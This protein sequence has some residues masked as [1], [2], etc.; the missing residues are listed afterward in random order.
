MSWSPGSGLLIR[1]WASIREHVA[2]DN[3]AS[4]LAELMNHFAN[5]GCGTL[6]E[7]VSENWP[8]SVEAYQAWSQ[9]TVDEEVDVGE[10]GGDAIDK[11]ADDQELGGEG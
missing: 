4:V 1:V 3:R 9:T 5:A 6:N 10:N 11:E 7:V 2:R 8:E